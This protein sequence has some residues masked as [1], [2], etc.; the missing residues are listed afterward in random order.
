MI[1]GQLSAN[2]LIGKKTVILSISYL[3]IEKYIKIKW[4]SAARSSKLS[5]QQLRK[6]W[7]SSYM[8]F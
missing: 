3:L 2:T 4:F 7:V 8:L 5:A 6:H 1:G